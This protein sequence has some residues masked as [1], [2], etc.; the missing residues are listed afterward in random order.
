MRVRFNHARHQ[1]TPST[2]KYIDI[3]PV[4]PFRPHCHGINPVPHHTDFA[5]KKRLP[6]TIEDVNI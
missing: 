1:G 4:Y 6:A 5:G 2:I 3:G